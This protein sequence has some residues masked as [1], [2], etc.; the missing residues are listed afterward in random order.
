[1][2]FNLKLSSLAVMVRLRGGSRGHQISHA[3]NVKNPN[4]FNVLNI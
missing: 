4:L 1:M 3:T 2:Y